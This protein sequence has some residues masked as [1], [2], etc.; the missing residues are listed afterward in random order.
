LSIMSISSSFR[1]WSKSENPRFLWIAF[2]MI[3]IFFYHYFE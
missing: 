3:L 1:L 2:L